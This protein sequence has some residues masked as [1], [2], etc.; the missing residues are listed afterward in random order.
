VPCVKVGG[1]RPPTSTFLG[2]SS[3]SVCLTLG[4]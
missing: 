3:P 2:T 4:A 1:G